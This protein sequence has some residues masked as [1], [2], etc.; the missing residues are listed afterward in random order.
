MVAQNFRIKKIKDRVQCL[1]I[2]L[3]STCSDLRLLSLTLVLVV[4]ESVIR[5][6][7]LA[8]IN[9]HPILGLGRQILEKCEY[10]YQM[11]RR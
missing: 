7:Q 5:P 3:S 8:L 6:R 10:T 1:I 2:F 4:S 9:I 11:D